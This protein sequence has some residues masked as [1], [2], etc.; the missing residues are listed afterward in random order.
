MQRLLTVDIVVGIMPTILLLLHMARKIRMS[1]SQNQ[2]QDCESFLSCP[3]WNFPT[4]ELRV[5]AE[6]GQ[7]RCKALTSPDPSTSLV[8]PAGSAVRRY[9]VASTS[10]HLIAQLP[11]AST[12]RPPNLLIARLSDRPTVRS[13]DQPTSRSPESLTSPTLRPRDRLTGRPPDRST[14]QPPNHPTIHPSNRPTTRP[15]D[16]PTT[17]TS[18]QLPNQPSTQPPNHPIIQPPNHS[19]TRPSIHPSNHSIIQSPD[20]QITQ[21]PN[22]DHPSIYPTIQP[23][24]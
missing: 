10:A 18:I 21:P 16:Q 12:P 19:N 13:P 1:Y 24:K 3:K 5:P 14:I 9:S 20:H 7:L 22:F 6:G 23:H 8:N 4:E 15:P 11:D 17:R 2:C